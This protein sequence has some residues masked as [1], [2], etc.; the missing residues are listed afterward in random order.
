MRDHCCNKGFYGV[1]ARRISTCNFPI[2]NTKTDPKA[3]LFENGF[4]Q[5]DS[6]I[7]PS[8]AFERLHLDEVCVACSV[9]G[10]LLRAQHLAGMSDAEL[11]VSHA[12][13]FC[14]A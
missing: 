2:C 12:N 4:S 9:R 14:V 11:E 3:L 10:S 13:S 7:S 6:P 1:V 8:V 5:S